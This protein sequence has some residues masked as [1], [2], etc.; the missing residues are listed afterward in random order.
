MRHEP[1]GG[2]FPICNVAVPLS[3]LAAIDPDESTFT[4]GAAIT[5]PRVLCPVEVRLT[6]TVGLPLCA[7]S[8]LFVLFPLVLAYAAAALRRERVSVSRSRRENPGQARNQWKQA[9]RNQPQRGAAPVVARKR[10]NVRRPKG[11]AIR[12]MVNLVNRRREEPT[13][14]GGGR[15]PSRMA[16]AV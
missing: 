2:V 9:S 14:C 7:L 15:Q 16:R 4:A 13:D 6:A 1:A 3:Q 10:S 11:R 5:N 8:I 12:V